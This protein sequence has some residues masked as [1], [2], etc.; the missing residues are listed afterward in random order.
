MGVNEDTPL[1]KKLNNLEGTFTLFAL[2]A[3]GVIL[4]FFSIRLVLEVYLLELPSE[5]E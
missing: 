3:A 4:I 1:Q 5:E 2:Y